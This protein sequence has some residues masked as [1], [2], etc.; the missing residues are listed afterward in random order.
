MTLVLVLVTVSAVLLV[1]RRMGAD[2]RW[3]VDRR[4][5]SEFAALLAVQDANNAAVV[6]R[7]RTLV[8]SPRIHAAI[9][10]NGLDLLYSIA[11][12]ELHALIPSRRVMPGGSAMPDSGDE[13]M[14]Q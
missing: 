1:Q 2:L 3:N 11:E 8:R 9:E 13:S 7:C 14:I 12:D 6:D 4:F 10:D 5:E